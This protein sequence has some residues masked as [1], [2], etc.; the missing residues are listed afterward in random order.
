[1]KYMKK[2]PV[3]LYCVYF[4]QA[5]MSICLL[6]SYFTYT[7]ILSSFLIWCSKGGRLVKQVSQKTISNPLHPVHM[8]T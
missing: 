3:R 7:K 5:T 4:L 2:K 6:H 8:Y 1:M